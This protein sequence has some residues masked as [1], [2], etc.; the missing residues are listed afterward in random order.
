MPLARGRSP[1]WIAG[2]ASGAALLWLVSS[3]LRRAARDRQTLIDE[4]TDATDWQPVS[5]AGPDDLTLIK[6][7]GPAMARSLHDLGVTSFAQLAEANPEELRQR[8][9]EAGLVLADPKSWREQARAA[10]RGDW[11]RF[12]A[13]QAE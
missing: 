5:R 8:A 9:E 11:S 6:G 13:L 1:L 4:E 12:E 2:A 10:A 7:I 3:R